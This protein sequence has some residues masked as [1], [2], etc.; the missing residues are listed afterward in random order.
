[1]TRDRR[2]TEQDSRTARGYKVDEFARREGV[3][4]STVQRWIDKGAVKVSRL[5]PR[6]GV[7]VDY[8]DR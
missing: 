8:L 1:M 4:K 3:A 2:H 5:A 6:Y 7:R